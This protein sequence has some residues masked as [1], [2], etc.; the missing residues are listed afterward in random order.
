MI[1]AP[2]TRVAVAEARKFIWS[3]SVCQAGGL[4][5]VEGAVV[6]NGHC[7]LALQQG[8]AVHGGK[9]VFTGRCG[10]RCGRWGLTVHGR[11]VQGG[12]VHGTRSCAVRYWQ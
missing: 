9:M 10:G 7:L 4:Q 5:A 12:G 6:V 3:E 8:M 2:C 11:K 1:V